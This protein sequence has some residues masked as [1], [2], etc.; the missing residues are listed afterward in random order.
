V[1]KAKPKKPAKPAKNVP[2]PLDVERATT[3]A[4]SLELVTAWYKALAA[5]KTFKS[6][7]EGRAYFY[8]ACWSND[9]DLEGAYIELVNRLDNPQNLPEDLF[10][11]ELV[12]QGRYA[13][14]HSFFVTLAP[15]LYARAVPM[16]NA[17]LD[18]PNKRPT[19]RY[20]EI[21]E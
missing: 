20:D 21:T 5:S 7:C 4:P 15:S 17:F 2:K 14:L 9:A 19:G 12:E 6:Q 1:A 13:E 8:E 10:E 16:I 11:E 3:T 18:A